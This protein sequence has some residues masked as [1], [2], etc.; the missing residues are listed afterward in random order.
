[1]AIRNLSD[2]SQGNPTERLD[3]QPADYSLMMADRRVEEASRRVAEQIRVVAEIE[4]A[5]DS[6]VVAARAL[7]EMEQELKRATEH[8]AAI[9]L[10]ADESVAEEREAG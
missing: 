2:A 8:R 5:G 7:Q 10:R 6:S 9:H 3:G 1:M 4:A